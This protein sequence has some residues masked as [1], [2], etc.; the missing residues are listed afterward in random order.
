MLVPRMKREVEGKVEVAVLISPGFGAGWSTWCHDEKD[1]EILLFHKDL[2]ELVL[3]GKNGSAASLAEEMTDA[4]VGGAESLMVAWIPEGCRF[5]IHE[6]DGSENL[7][8]EET[9]DWSVA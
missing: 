8:K 3:E 6:Y 9:I 7:V 5:I 2:V 1:T 4:Y